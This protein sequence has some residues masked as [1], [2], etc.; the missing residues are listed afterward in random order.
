MPPVDILGKEKAANTLHRHMTLAGDKRTYKINSRIVETIMGEMSFGA[1]EQDDDD[2]ERN[3]D[4]DMGN[5]AA[6]QGAKKVK[7]K[8][9]VLKLFSK[10]KS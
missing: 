4:P 6:E 2:S 10:D 3:S 9:N 1:D 8:Q 5:K 7:E